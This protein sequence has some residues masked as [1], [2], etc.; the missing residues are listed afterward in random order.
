MHGNKFRRFSSSYGRSISGQSSGQKPINNDPPFTPRRSAR[1]DILRYP[2]PP[3]P[4]DRQPSVSSPAR[5]TG[6][7]RAIQYSRETSRIGQYRADRRVNVCRKHICRGAPTTT[8]FLEVDYTLGWPAGGGGGVSGVGEG[9]TSESPSGLTCH[10]RIGITFTELT[11]KTRER[12][13]PTDQSRITVHSRRPITVHGSQTLANH[14]SR[15]TDTGQSQIAVHS[16]R[17]ITSQE[18]QALTNHVSMLTATGQSQLTTH[19]SR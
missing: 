13:L 17:P 6:N 16:R 1:A 14:S 5:R 15:L 19:S 8:E 2:S 9:M 18:S 3:R 10:C 7:R 11:D 12:I 4:Q